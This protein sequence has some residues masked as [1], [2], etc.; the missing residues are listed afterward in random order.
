MKIKKKDVIEFANNVAKAINNLENHVQIFIGED[1][2]GKLCSLQEIKK[3]FENMVNNDNLRKFEKKHK[4]FVDKDWEF[5][6]S[7]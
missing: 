3:E 7:Y 2:S 4:M 6:W 1:G 5:Y